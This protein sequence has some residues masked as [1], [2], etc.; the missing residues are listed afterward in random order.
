LPPSLLLAPLSP[1]REDAAPPVEDNAIDK[2]RLVAILSIVSG[3][4]V[5]TVNDVAIKW[6]SGD[7]PVHEIVLVRTLVAIPLTVLVLAP[8]EGGPMRWR[9]AHPF[10]NVARGLLL[11]LA[12]LG[13]FLG[14]AALPLAE[15]MSL[16]FVA[17]L[18][19]TALSAP[20]LGE[21]VGPRRWLAVLAGMLG[22]VVML[23]PGEGMLQIAA[24]L[25]M[26]AALAY[27]LMQ[28]IARRLGPTDRAST[29]AL[30][31]QVTFLG[32]ALAIG[33]A[34]G[35][36]RYG[37]TGDPSLDFLLRAW[38]WPEPADLAIMGLC[39]VCIG[40]GGYLITQAYRIGP[41]SM[42]APFEYVALPW[43][44][45][46]GYGLWAEIP[47]SVTVLGMGL[48][49]GSGLYVLLRERGREAP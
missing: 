26:I 42:V 31:L 25:P 35:D 1:F 20:L 38:R 18:F 9:T 17:P 47:D 13:Y 33:L 2:Q 27:A 3:M 30:Y 36:G 46:L 5:L 39:G 6:L 12:N 10:L 4:I 44:A 41:A 21:K 16:F 49:V 7:Y 45:L 15:T 34:V 32:V 23:R 43:G 48:I 24:V 40:V 11:A 37:G 14:L 28:S 19:I 22:V 29:M 8:F